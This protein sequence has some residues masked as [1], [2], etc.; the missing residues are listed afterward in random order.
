MKPSLFASSL[1][2]AAAYAKLSSADKAALVTFENDPTSKDS[3]KNAVAVLAGANGSEDIIEAQ[4][5]FTIA[6][7]NASVAAEDDN[8]KEMANVL[9]KLDTLIIHSLTDDNLAKVIGMRTTVLPS[10]E[11]F[12]SSLFSN[13]KIVKALLELQKA[14]G[15]KEELL[16]N[17]SPEQLAI[18]MQNVAN[19]DKELHDPAF[20][21]A[22]AAHLKSNSKCYEYL[23]AV[24]VEYIDLVF[25]AKSAVPFTKAIA[26]LPS[27]YLQETIE[28]AHADEA[29][30]RIVA[31]IASLSKIARIM[32]AA[33]RN[34]SFHKDDD[35]QVSSDEA[36]FEFISAHADA[37]KAIRISP[38]RFATIDFDTQRTMLSA[39]TSLPDD[40]LF[41][42]HKSKNGIRPKRFATPEA[43]L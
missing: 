12:G 17:F 36:D 38:D 1:L 23:S 33:K 3:T 11:N 43:N 2:V 22:L 15:T 28:P 18:F 4:E 19:F 7:V 14:K 21:N 10:L 34:S 9:E 5:Y 13:A 26:N 29:D 37:I 27:D 39:H 42:G 8:A 30:F 31:H 41:P 6:K 32:S 25:K 35:S 40:I 20:L 24:T 16:N